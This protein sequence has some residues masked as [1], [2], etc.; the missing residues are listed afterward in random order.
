MQFE[1]IADAMIV[2]DLALLDAVTGGAAAAQQR[3]GF[4]FKN[5]AAWA[6]TGA[7]AASL[8]CLPTLATGPWTYGGCVALGAGAAAVW[9]TAAQ[10]GILDYGK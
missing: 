5:L 8:P 2:V 1:P 3:Q 6:G 10:T 4:S 9:N 7:A